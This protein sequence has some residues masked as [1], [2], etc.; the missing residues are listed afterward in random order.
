MSSSSNGRGG[1]RIKHKPSKGN[2]KRDRSGKEKKSKSTVNNGKTDPDY[3]FILGKN[4]RHR[5]SRVLTIDDD[6]YV[7]DVSLTGR[8]GRIILSLVRCAYNKKL[9][10]QKDL[11]GCCERCGGCGSCCISCLE[12]WFCNPC[13]AGKMGKT[14]EVNGFDI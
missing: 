2:G 11:P 4:Q 13:V 14:L 12:I 7:D 3:L 10:S 8:V 6:D 5:S 1:D 9:K